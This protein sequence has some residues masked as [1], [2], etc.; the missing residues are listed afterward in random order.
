MDLYLDLKKFL[1][2]KS[3]L[4]EDLIWLQFF[5]IPNVISATDLLI[6]SLSITQNTKMLG[7]LKN[8]NLE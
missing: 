5:L 1:L 2:L 8:S 7:K 3:L 6:H 4:E